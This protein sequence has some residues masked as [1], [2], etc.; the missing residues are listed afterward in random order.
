MLPRSAFVGANVVV[1]RRAVQS[2]ARKLQA[3]ARLRSNFIATSDTAL[4]QQLLGHP[5]AAEF[6]A[7]LGAQVRQQPRLR[8]KVSRLAARLSAAR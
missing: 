7:D 4:L 3:D 8:A 5:Y 6:L 1:R 2:F